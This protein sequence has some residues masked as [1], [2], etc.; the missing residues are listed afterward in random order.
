VKTCDRTGSGDKGFSSRLEKSCPY[1][2]RMKRIQEC[3]R[4]FFPFLKIYYSV[5]RFVLSK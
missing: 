5:A 2:N 4:L 3:K 1:V